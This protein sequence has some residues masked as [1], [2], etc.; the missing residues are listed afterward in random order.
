MEGCII[1]SAW[2]RQTVDGNSSPK[3]YPYWEE[4]VSELKKDGREV[5][6]VLSK[7]EKKLVQWCLEDLPFGKLK[8]LLD[9]CKTWISVDNFF[10]HFAHY[11]NKP[12]FVLWGPSDENIFGY[13]ENFNLRSND[14]S[15]KKDQWSLW[16]INDRS[17][18]IKPQKVMENINEKIRW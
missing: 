2:S 9:G 4:L 5:I 16:S 6:Q 11:Y 17:N 12:G 3:N 13:E 8:E 10:H 14:S 15:L 18:F 7:G 1:I